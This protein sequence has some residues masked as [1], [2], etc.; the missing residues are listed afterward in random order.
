MQN[1]HKIKLIIGEEW[2][3]LRVKLTSTFTSG[4]MKLMFPLVKDCGDKLAQVLE[5]M[6]SEPFDVKDLCARYTTDVIGT[7][8]FGIEIHSLENPDSEFRTMGKQLFEPR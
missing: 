5:S 6:S 2:K 1:I 8:A 4:K 7:C 3:N